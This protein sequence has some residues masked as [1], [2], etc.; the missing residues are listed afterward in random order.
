MEYVPA[1]ADAG[2]FTFSVVVRVAP[3]LGLSAATL[4]AAV[5]PAGAVTV[6]L[7][8]E[9]AHPVSLLVTETVYVTG[10]FGAPCCCTGD[11]V[12]VGAFRTHG[13]GTWYV[14]AAEPTNVVATAFV[15]RGTTL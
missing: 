7:K 15:A 5:Q 14:A 4:N 12:S 13:I 3:G 6:S 11:T 1:A 8:L 2:G 10:T 9:D